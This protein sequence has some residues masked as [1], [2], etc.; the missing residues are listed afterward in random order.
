MFNGMVKK[1]IAEG[2]QQALERIGA[3]AEQV[4]SP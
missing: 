1:H 2:T 4:T 3:A